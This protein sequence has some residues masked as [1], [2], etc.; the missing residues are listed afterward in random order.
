MMRRHQGRC[1]L[2]WLPARALFVLHRHA[3]SPPPRLSSRQYLPPG[4]QP[5]CT[6]PARLLCRR[7]RY[8]V[9]DPGA[10]LE[11]V[12]ACLPRLAQLTLPGEWAVGWAAPVPPCCR[13]GGHRPGLPSRP[14]PGP[15]PLED[16]VATPL[17]RLLLAC[18]GCAGAPAVRVV[19]PS[20]VPGGEGRIA[21]IC[22]AAAQA[23]AGC[24]KRAGEGA[25]QLEG[26][27]CV[28]CVAC[29]RDGPLAGW[30]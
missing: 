17:A 6:T 23:A 14:G 15:A 22:A 10:E 19:L 1:S 9:V 7:W 5:W 27:P 30:R 13:A 20:S 28:E 21:N 25:G 2:A 26:V 18:R 16:L 12:A 29:G 4:L 24:A 8:S 11:R 3:P